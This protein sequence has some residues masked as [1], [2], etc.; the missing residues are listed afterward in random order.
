MKYKF[1]LRW[2]ILVLILIGL[3]IVIYVKISNWKPIE[4]QVIRTPIRIAKQSQIQPV[5]TEVAA[6]QP[7]KEEIKKTPLPK[8]GIPAK[9]K[10]VVNTDGTKTTIIAGDGS[11]P[12]DINK[13]ASLG[14]SGNN[15]YTVRYNDYTGKYSQFEQPL[16]DYLNSL[17]WM[18]EITYLYG[19]DLK[20]AGNTGWSGQWS[21][22]Y[23]VNAKGY[24]ISSFGWITLN[25]F[26]AKESIMLD[27]LK[28]VLSHE[29]GHHYTLY[30]KWVDW[31]LGMS[32]RFPDSYYQVRPL[33]K[34]STIT[35]CSIDWS[36]CDAEIAAEDYSY[37][38]SG[39]GY[40]AMSKTFGFPSSPG[41][42]NWM[43]NIANPSGQS[44]VFVDNPPRVSITS[45]AEG[46]LLQNQVSVK[47]E[48]T[49]DGGVKK[50]E[51]Y[52]NDVKLGEDSAVPYELNLNTASYQNGNYIIKVLAFDEK[53]SAEAKIQ[54]TFQNQSIDT[55]KP[56]VTL[57]APSTNPYDWEKD[58]LII[59]ARAND[60]IKVV[61]MSIFINDQ[62]AAE[63]E[64]NKIARQWV[65]SAEDLPGEYNLKVKAYDAVGNIGEIS[66]TVKKLF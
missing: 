61:K 58:N 17:K 47:G 36:R 56:V 21:G 5:S 43:E 45:P 27:Y 59:Q 54:V 18:N 49:D 53:Q 34:E 2:L 8:K 63:Q 37:I 28:L 9:G 22:S 51:F 40:H 7:I 19:I 15:P 57:F 1:L 46:A 3:A 33:A 52:L 11:T 14:P 12:T 26:Y 35:D 50:V 13:I 48:A 6:E 31:D 60:N 44:K 30:H 41:T 16:K 24:I 65:P 55:E 66:I 23:T 25:T 10:T 29:Y 38:Y 20:D 42:K 4:Q 64:G 32:T 62:L 39:Y